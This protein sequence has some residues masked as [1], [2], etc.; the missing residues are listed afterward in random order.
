MK[1][2][3]VPKANEGENQRIIVKAN[4]VFKEKVK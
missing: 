2:T 3:K 4:I 1:N